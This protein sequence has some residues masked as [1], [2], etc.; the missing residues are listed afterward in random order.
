MLKFINLYNQN[1]N[2]LYIKLNLINFY[3]LYIHLCNYIDLYNQSKNNLYI[4]IVH[5]NL[6]K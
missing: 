3:N 4:K 5:K 6:C 2:N 1:K